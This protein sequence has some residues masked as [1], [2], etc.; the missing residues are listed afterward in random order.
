MGLR[1]EHSPDGFRDTEDRVL[2]N[3]SKFI[4]HNLGAI[5]WANPASPGTERYCDIEVA[6]LLIL[7][8]IE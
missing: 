1:V 4:V 6:H 2:L 3:E 7:S 8:D 5:A